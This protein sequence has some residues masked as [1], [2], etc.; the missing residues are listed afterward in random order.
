MKRRLFYA[1]TAVLLLAGGV[2][3]R[4]TP[5]PEGVRKNRNAGD[6]PFAVRAFHLDF[7]TE[8]M[9]L[10]AMK[11]LAGRLAAQGVNALVMEWEATFPFD[12]HATLSNG[13]AF[14]R[15]E[16]REFVGWCADRGIDVIPLQNCFGH[17][18]YILRHERYGALREDAKDPS[19]VCPLKIDEA[20]AV[21]SELFAEVAALHP[22]RYFHIGA[23]ETYLLGLCP[24]CRETAEKQGKSRLFVDYVKAMCRIVHDMGKTP[25]IWAD[26]ILKHPEA[27]DEL[28]EELI[29]VDWNY[30]WEPDRFGALDNLLSRGARMWGAPAL[31]SGPDNIYLT[32]WMKHFDN[33]AV[34]VDFARRHGYEGIVETSWSTSGTYGYWFDAGNEILA[35]QPVRLVYPMSAFD[36]LQEACCEALNSDCMFE[37]EPFVHRYARARLGLDETGAAVLWRYFSMPQETVSVTA[38]GVKDARG[39]DVAEV[40]E[41]CVEMRSE[42]ARLKPRRGKDQVAHYLLMLDI[43]INYLRFRSVE[44]RYQSA[45]C[46]REQAAGLTG[47]L[48]E[49]LCETEALDRR[50]A[51]LNKN[52]LKASEVD[53]VNRMRS[54]KM[55]SLYERLTNNR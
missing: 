47:E 3:V 4:A 45:S 12:K 14:S 37:P 51:R 2:Q 43:R 29:F 31:R 36:I 32:Q 46:D 49:L 25:V 42:M 48:K 15:D 53:Y 9:T 17:C 28:P 13:N 26:I 6:S 27:L 20:T 55:R 54:L 18:E 39:R 11:A 33:L 24:R 22:S 1:L 38:S 10:D 21:F 41:E 44:A 35:M 52:Y 50:F 16:V 40:L 5:E 34:F 7:R 30:G 23:D 8:V 19:Q